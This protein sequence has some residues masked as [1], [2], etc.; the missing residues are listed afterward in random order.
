MQDPRAPTALPRRF[1]L[2]AGLGE[3]IGFGSRRWDKLEQRCLE[4]EL[5]Y[6]CSRYCLS[7]A[8]T[9]QAPFR[10]GTP[11][12]NHPSFSNSHQHRCRRGPGR[13]PGSASRAR[14]QQRPTPSTTASSS[15]AF[16]SGLWFSQE[17][18]PDQFSQW[19]LPVCVTAVKMLAKEEVAF[20]LQ[21]S[22]NC[23]ILTYHKTKQMITLSSPAAA[24]P[25]A[26]GGSSR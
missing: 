8:R 26:A 24:L 21:E 16:S 10:E 15:L 6:L 20:C 4:A 3:G 14:D 2:S 9:P 17:N 11:L 25:E 12:R 7:P 18:S 1:N 23:M 5:N 19:S 13:S 22:W